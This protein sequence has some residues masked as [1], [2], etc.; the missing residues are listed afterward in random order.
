MDECPEFEG[1]V[2]VHYSAAATFYA[3][4][5]PSG[6]GG[7]RREH[8]RATPSWFGGPPRMDCAFVKDATINALSNPPDIVRILLFFSFDYGGQHYDCALVR[9]FEYSSPTVDEDTGMYVVRPSSVSDTPGFISV[10][11]LTSIFRAAHLDPVYG[12]SYVPTH[13]QNYQSLDAF[14]SFFVNKFIDHHAFE[15]LHYV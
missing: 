6:Q 1:P 9:S 3:P 8:I 2:N 4:S 10:I 7:M 5:D 13:L 12:T 11:P 15:L 14:Q